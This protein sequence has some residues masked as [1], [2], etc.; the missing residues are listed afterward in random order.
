MAVPLIAFAVL[1]VG[2][3]LFDLLVV[4]P[5]VALIAFVLWLAFGDG[6]IGALLS[7]PW[8]WGPVAAIGVL[9]VAAGVFGEVPEAAPRAAR[10]TRA[11]ATPPVARERGRCPVCDR[12]V[13]LTPSRGR[14]K[15][16]VTKGQRCAGM[17]Q[18]PHGDSGLVDDAE[19]ALR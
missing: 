8:L 11:A 15:T 4:L 7:S 14:I 2:G 13:S 16:H 1:L 10:R 19:S 6:D 3:F 18:R 17:G 9:V 12:M 5:P